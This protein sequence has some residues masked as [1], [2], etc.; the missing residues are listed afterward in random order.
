MF[1]YQLVITEKAPIDSVRVSEKVVSQVLTGI[2]WGDL[3]RNRAVIARGTL[4]CP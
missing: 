1:Y 4:C 3:I 2:R